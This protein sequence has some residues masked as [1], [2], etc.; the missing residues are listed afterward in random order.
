M[1]ES[2]GFNEGKNAQKFEFPQDPLWIDVPEHF[3]DNKNTFK[4]GGLA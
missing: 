2:N 3:V 4:Q 1:H